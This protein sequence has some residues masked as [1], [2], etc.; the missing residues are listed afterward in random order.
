M[1]ENA[2]SAALVFLLLLQVKHFICDGPLQT[3]EMVHDKGIYGLPRGL[4]HAGLHGIGTFIVCL[5][6]GLDLRLALA[7]GAI[8]SAVHYH[9][10]FTKERFVRSHGWSFN[11]AQFWWAIVGDQFIHN[12]TY[13][14][15]A[16]YVFA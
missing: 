9:V 4:L 6:V 7:L 12:V 15:Y 2:V 13:I 1:P 8:D 5:I 11:N 10:D 16:A 3:R 14:A